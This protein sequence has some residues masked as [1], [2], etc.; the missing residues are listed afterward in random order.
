M[1]NS[2]P[3]NGGYQSQ[4]FYKKTEQKLKKTGLYVYN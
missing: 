2:M 3:L 1:E 4:L